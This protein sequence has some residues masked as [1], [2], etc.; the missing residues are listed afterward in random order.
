MRLPKLEFHPQPGANKYMIFGT[1]NVSKCTILG[2]STM[3]STSNLINHPSIKNTKPKPNP[4][5][6]KTP[7]P[8][9]NSLHFL[10][11]PQ[12]TRLNH[13]PQNQS[14]SGGNTSEATGVIDAIARQNQERWSRFAT[15]S[16]QISLPSIGREV[17]RLDQEGD[18]RV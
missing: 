8:P 18:Q 14:E 4:Q 15:K 9:T 11:G 13:N 7:N 2:F 5:T 16:D 12:F 3:A 6:T 17:Q 1:P 10:G